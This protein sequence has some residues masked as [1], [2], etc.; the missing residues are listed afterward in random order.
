MTSRV[1]D[2]QWEGCHRWLLGPQR[3]GRAV[4]RRVCFLLRGIWTLRDL[5]RGQAVEGDGVLPGS[6]FI[7]RD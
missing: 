5:G 6:H 3:I 1:K 4:Q 7:E 2:L